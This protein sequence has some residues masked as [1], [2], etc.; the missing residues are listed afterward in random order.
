MADFYGFLLDMIDGDL[1]DDSSKQK[2]SG[3]SNNKAKKSYVDFLVNETRIALNKSDLRLVDGVA[4][5][6]SEN[7]LSYEELYTI[8]K[9]TLRN[10]LNYALPD[11]DIYKKLDELTD[12]K[13]PLSML[14]EYS[15]SDERRLRCAVAMNPKSTIEV[16]ERVFDYESKVEVNPFNIG[17]VYAYIANNPNCSI[18]LKKKI[19]ETGSILGNLGLAVDPRCPSAILDILEMQNQLEDDGSFY[20]PYESIVR[21]NPNYKR[22]LDHSLELFIQ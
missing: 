17:I 11:P 14:E 1:H 18:S 20:T 10:Q 12:P 5:Q 13:C 8:V 3:K 9:V 6:L 22:I 16:L 4:K 7:N 2:K 21:K 19:L 15:Q